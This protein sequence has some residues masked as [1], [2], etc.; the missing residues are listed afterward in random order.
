M[1]LPSRPT[2]LWVLDAHACAMALT[3]SSMPA[4]AIHTPPVQTNEQTSLVELTRVNAVDCEQP[5]S[6]PAALRLRSPSHPPAL[7]VSNAATGEL[8]TYFDSPGFRSRL[9]AC[10]PSVANLASDELLRRFDREVLASEVTHNFNAANAADTHD[11]DLSLLDRPW[12]VNLWQL[13][14]M[15]FSSASL[16]PEPEE[17]AEVNIYGFRPFV[18]PSRPSVTEASSR[19][20]YT[21]VNWLRVDLGVEHYGDTAIVFKPCARLKTEPHANPILEPRGQCP[22]IHVASRTVAPRPKRTSSPPIAA[23]M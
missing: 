10:C 5:L 11:I 9:T 14:V 7:A 15:N 3:L 1:A 13:S 22:Q 2:L 8:R 4:F 20:S 23:A 18:T 17:T 19:M 16:Q 21:A 6:R 12:F